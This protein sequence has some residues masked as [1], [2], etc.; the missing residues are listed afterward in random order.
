MTLANN[1]Q[2]HTVHNPFSLSIVYRIGESFNGWKI[3]KNKIRDIE[4]MSEED[5]SL[6]HRY[7]NDSL[8]SSTD[9]DDDD[10]L[11]ESSPGEPDY[12]QSY[13]QELSKANLL[14]RKTNVL[15]KPYVF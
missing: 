8:A 13:T 14:L 11:S 1:Q 6:Q 15:S 7:E 3:F 5:K 10:S 2:T 4:E 9:G 12:E